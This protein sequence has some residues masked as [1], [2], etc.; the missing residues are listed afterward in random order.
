MFALQAFSDSG[1]ENKW[2]QVIVNDFAVVHGEITDAELRT[3]DF[4][5]LDVS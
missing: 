4:Q 5:N 3:H 2:D 1:I